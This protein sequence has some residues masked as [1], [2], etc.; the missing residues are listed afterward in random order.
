MVLTFSMP[1]GHHRLDWCCPGGG[2]TI[3]WT[4]AVLV[5]DTLGGPDIFLDTG[6]AASGPGAVLVE[7]TLGGPDLFLDTGTAASGPGAVLVRTP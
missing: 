7:D 6:T 1:Q 4:G 2:G 5:E 3:V